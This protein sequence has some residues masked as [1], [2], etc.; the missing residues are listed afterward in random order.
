[1]KQKRFRWPPATSLALSEDGHL[2]VCVGR[3]VVVVDLTT[4][5]RISSIL[6][7]RNPM[8]ACLSLDGRLLAIKSSEGDLAYVHTSTYTLIHVQSGRGRGAGCCPAFSPHGCLLIDGT[9][10]GDLIVN[11]LDGVQTRRQTFPDELISR[12]THDRS[13]D[14]WLTQ[15]TVRPVSDRHSPTSYLTLRSWSQWD[16]PR[17]VFDLGM[18]VE[19]ATLSPDGR[20]VAFLQSR[21]NLLHVLRV[22]DGKVLTTGG[23][24][25]T[26]GS[27]YELAWSPDCR[28]FGIVTKTGFSIFDAAD[29]TIQGTVSCKYPSSLAFFPDGQSIVFGTWE[30]S[31]LVRLD[32]LLGKD[33]PI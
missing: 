20:L 7:F 24:I 32:V 17:H 8:H 31:A 23:P 13:R 27:G 5:R 25:R 28:F 18:H 26:G 30:R 11:S 2:L 21:E 16:A 3:R 9:W 4:R 33:T 10:N 1:M 15:H 19:S 14:L 6:P 29:L 12:V 22:S